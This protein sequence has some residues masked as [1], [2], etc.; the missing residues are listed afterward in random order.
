MD[1]SV[2]RIKSSADDR[3]FLISLRLKN[4]N[5]EELNDS[6]NE[7]KLLVK[8][9]GAVITDTAVIRRDRIDPAF[10]IGSGHLEIIKNTV[11]DKKITLIVFDINQLRPAQVRNLEERLKC[12]VVCRTEII[13][14]I[15]AKRARSKEASIQVELAQLKYILPR[16]KG[17]GDALSQTGAGIGTR[18]PGEKMLET[19]RRHILKRISKLDK[20]LKEISNHRNLIRKSR[21]GMLKGAVVGYTNAGKSTLINNLARDDLFVEDRLFATLDSYTRVVF[22]DADKKVLLTDTVGFIRNLPANLLESFKSTLEE[23]VNADF[24]IHVIDITSHDIEKKINIVDKELSVLQ[25]NNKPIILFFNKAD[26]SSG[27]VNVVL[28]K[29][30]NAVTGSALKNT[31]THELKQKIIGIYNNMTTLIG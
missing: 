25:S 1:A 2:N 14:D 30:T 11:K 31:G 3:A 29:Y 20:K 19:D 4:E 21:S 15:F 12:R 23:I 13:L 9:A 26:S 6:L 22:L 18:G 27:N 10:I 17:L 5:T 16:L 7:L 8:T 28:E 24:L